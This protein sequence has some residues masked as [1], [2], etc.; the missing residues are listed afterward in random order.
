MS[1]HEPVA[2]PPEP[3]EFPSLL[4]MLDDVFRAGDGSMG[5]D[6][7]RLLTETNRANLR[8]VVEGGEVVSHAG[9]ITR[10]AA[11]SGVGVRVALMGGVATAESARGKGHATRCVGALSGHAIR[12][13]VDFMV[14]SGA[15]GLYQRLGARRVGD[16]MEICITREQAN[17]LAREGIEVR[18]FGEE[19]LLDAVD[20][21]AAEE[22]HFVRPLE[23]WLAAMRAAFAYNA[24]C[25]FLGAW[26]VG[27]LAA[28]ALVHDPDRDGLS[29]VIE[30]AGARGVLIGALSRIMEYVDAKRLRIHLG[31]QD[32]VLGARLA[33][34]GIE[35]KPVPS[36][37]TTVVL[38]FE[39]LMEKLR[40]RFLER[41]GESAARELSFSEEGPPLGPDN[42]FRM[43]CGPD[44]I[45]IEGRGTLAEF[46]FGTPGCSPDGEAP[47]CDKESCVKLYGAS[48]PFRAALPAPSTWSGL[49]FT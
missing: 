2:R 44:V 20:L 16:D 45:R 25:S 29:R 32:R 21:Y 17:D 14:I 49:N 18:P 11:L 4:R 30:Y 42:K 35:G 12:D 1:D 34:A 40:A 36:D 8:V 19:H 3:S 47:P 46:I 39:S 24:R 41:A 33:A 15:R 13:G 37:G 38:N 31:H 27:R 48:A 23:D 7:P 10:D 26:E 5:A 6:F 28:Y 9:V 43:A 22:V